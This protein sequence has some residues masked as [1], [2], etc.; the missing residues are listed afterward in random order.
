MFLF[1]CSLFF[2]FEWALSGAQVLSG[3]IEN[4]DMFF[5]S[6][7]LDSITHRHFKEHY[8]SETTTTADTVFNNPGCAFK[9]EQEALKK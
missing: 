5:Q 8:R 4:R 3:A 6:F 2:V 1:L 9:Y 7:S